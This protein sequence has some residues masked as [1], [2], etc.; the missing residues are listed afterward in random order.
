[1]PPLSAVR[2]ELQE[3][4]RYLTEHS[5]THSAKWYGHYHI[6]LVNYLWELPLILISKIV[7]SLKA[8]FIVTRIH[9]N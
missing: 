8:S 7:F 4:L 3:A 1:M 5:L 2:T 9:K 6:G